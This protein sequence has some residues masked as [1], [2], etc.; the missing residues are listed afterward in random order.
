V[1]EPER[2]VVRTQG[3]SD[4]V[5]VLTDAFYPGWKATLDGTPVAVLR[6]NTAMRAV[7]VPAGD[8]R[9][10]MRYRPRSLWIGTVLACAGAAALSGAIAVGRRRR[11][12]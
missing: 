12:T 9:V 4:A 7:V 11:G 3:A 8:H 2:V 10:E 6:A 1:D 5:L